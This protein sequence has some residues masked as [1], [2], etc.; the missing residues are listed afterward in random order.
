M[1]Q[2]VGPPGCSIAA[3]KIAVLIIG[4]IGLLFLGWFILGAAMGGH[5]EGNL[6]SGIIGAAWAIAYWP[7]TLIVIG[8]AFWAS[9]W[10]MKQL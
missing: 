6:Y 2:S 4:W 10:W 9:I 1:T 3:I 8:L 7:V 5:S